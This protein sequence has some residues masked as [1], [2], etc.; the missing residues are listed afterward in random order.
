MRYC[1]SFLVPVIALAACVAALAQTPTYDNLGRTPSA[2]EIRAWDTS[3]GVEGKELP[4]GSGTAK[5]GAPIY[6]QKCVQCHGPTG[7]EGPS[8]VLVG[9]KGMLKS[10][11]PVKPLCA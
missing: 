8:R 11:N 4:P 7:T 6:A 10:L 5:Q 9:G 1:H 3:V 2:E